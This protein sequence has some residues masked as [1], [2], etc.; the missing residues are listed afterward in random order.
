MADGLKFNLYI[1]LIVCFIVYNPVLS[2]FFHF[3]KSR[4]Y[5]WLTYAICNLD[6]WE[7]V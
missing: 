4:G 1:F 6:T 3:K 2:R 5:Q 7:Q